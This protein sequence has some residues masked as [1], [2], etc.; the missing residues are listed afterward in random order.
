MIRLLASASTLL[1]LFFAAG[2][3]RTQRPPA[4]RP[5]S[6]L[7]LYE[8]VPLPYSGFGSMAVFREGVLHFTVGGEAL[9]YDESGHVQYA[10]S[11]T[12]S[13][14]L[15]SN[16]GWALATKKDAWRL[17]DP[18]TVV[19]AE[20]VRPFDKETTNYNHG[21]TGLLQLSGSM[22]VGYDKANE[23][24]LF[25]LVDRETGESFRFRY[26]PNMETDLAAL[27][28]AAA[29]N[30]QSGLCP[31]GECSITCNPPKLCVAGCVNSDPYCRCVSVQPAPEPPPPPPSPWV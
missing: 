17:V 10:D 8:S 5:A 27:R 29:A 1:L 16:D 20:E 31:N 19:G 14:R 13:I 30:C 7:K 2:D 6:D 22:F 21:L 4:P 3:D 9:G 28:S 23:A 12:V 18:R 15:A 26:R 25:E 24:W 11:E